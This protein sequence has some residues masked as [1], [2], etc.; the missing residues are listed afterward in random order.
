MM[1]PS[2]VSR[3]D[4]ERDKKYAL[5]SIGKGSVY[6]FFL[7]NH[8]WGWLVALSAMAAQIGILYVFVEGAEFDL[9]DDISDLV[10]SVCLYFWI[11]FGEIC[12]ESAHTCWNPWKCSYSASL[13]IIYLSSFVLI[14]CRCTRGSVLATRTRVEI[15]TIWSVQC[16]CTFG[17]CLERSAM[18][19]H[20][21]YWNP[22]KC[23]YSA[24]LAIISLSSFVL[25][26][27]RGWVCFGILMT[28]HL[29][30]DI[31]N[32]SKLI[33]L[34]GK[35]RHSLKSRIRFFFGGMFTI[36]TSLFALFV[37]TVYNQAIAASNTALIENSVIVLFITDLE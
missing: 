18:S 11:V 12:H 20:I 13:A 28:A 30:K 37:T 27:W 14:P 24:S 23:S 15:Q 19:Q 31:V 21:L 9:S 2:A 36:A 32:G 10:S 22:C 33:V 7:G 26:N 8:A 1:R 25:K 5:D 4:L 16:A 17:L 6:M 3:A 35:Q 29:L 34:S